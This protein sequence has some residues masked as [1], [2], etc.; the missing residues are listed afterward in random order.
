[1]HS[2]YILSVS[3]PGFWNSI[4]EVIAVSDYLFDI[5]SIVRD[6]ILQRWNPIVFNVANN[7]K[8]WFEKKYCIIVWLGKWRL[9][10]I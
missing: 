9:T 3:I 10:M 4:R 7:R 1:M 6:E 8:S 2:T 5:D